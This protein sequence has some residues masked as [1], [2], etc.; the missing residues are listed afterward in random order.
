MTQ[1]SIRQYPSL[2]VVIVNWNSKDYL[3]QCLRSIEEHGEGLA[4][5][6]V[7]VDGGSF[8]GCDAMLE[9]EFPYVDFVQSED[10]IGFARSNNLGFKKVTSQYVLLLNPDTELT[11]NALR[12]LMRAALEHPKAGIVGPRL[13]NSDGTLQA[14]CVQP[15]PTPLNQAL[16]SDF[17]RKRLKLSRFLGKDGSMVG[18]ALTPVPAVSG[19]AMLI[20]ALLFRSLGCFTKAYFMYAEDM[21]LCAKATRAGFKVLHEPCAEIVHHGGGSS[22]KSFSKFAVVMNLHALYLYMG[23]NHDRFASTRMRLFMLLSSL[24]RLAVLGA[25]YATT[26]KQSRTRLT[27]SL[28]RWRATASWA[29][30]KEPWAA[31]YK[32]AP[33]SP[34]SANRPLTS[35]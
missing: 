19:A 9:K 13:L 20:P 2:S 26:T 11:P 33:V 32:P 16:D 30:G 24:V 34:T 29:L 10:N 35:R 6:I 1:S 7:V 18:D 22:S 23:L 4:T 25:L 31:N 14:S 3:R 12:L 28:Q 15:L 21:D 5:Q 17:L 8:D 27:A